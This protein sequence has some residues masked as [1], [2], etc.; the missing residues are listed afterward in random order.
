MGRRC[1][2]SGK[3]RLVGMSVSHS[4]RHTKKVQLPNLQYKRFVDPQ[5]GLTVRLRISTTALKTIQKY[6]LA[7][8][9]K[10]YGTKLSE[11]T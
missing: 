2:V 7:S 10:R 6:G 3:G 11:L 9:L 5:T 1:D 4:H 8:A